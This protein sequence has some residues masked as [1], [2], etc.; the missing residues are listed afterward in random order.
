MSGKQNVLVLG[1]TGSIGENTLDVVARNPERFNVWGLTANTNQAGLF[2]QICKFNP[3]YV[4]LVDRSAAAVLRTRVSELGLSTEVLDGPEALSELAAH[5][6]VDSLMAAIVGAAGLP[7]AMAAAA[8]GKKILLANKESLVCAGR[9]FMDEVDRGGATLLPVD[10]EHNAIFQCM[11]A[12]AGCNAGISK[13]LLTGSGGPFRGRDPD[14]FG[15]VTVE[16]ACTHPNWS[17][18]RKIS[19]DSATMM[20]K[21]LELIEACWLFDIGESEIE[22]LLH[23]ESIVHSMVEYQ[24]GS[25]LAQLGHPDMR[26]PI[27]H[28]L[29]WPERCESGVPAFNWVGQKLNFEAPNVRRYPSLQLAR[30]VASKMGSLPI[31]MN[32]A[33][34]VAVEAFL[35]RR[36]AFTDIVNT[37]EGT[38]DRADFREP[39][40]LD[41]VLDIDSMARVR[42]DVVVDRRACQ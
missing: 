29:S 26:T 23:P 8:A 39:G 11:A 14:T 13:I 1:S 32:A 31:W 33:N 34:E 38:L 16:E 22:I 21:G 6:Q 3:E 17:M 24:D 30:Q 37:I 7:S 20:N 5:D 27:A 28:A 42:A 41:E 36:I 12:S 40:S 25:T 35:Q 15:E 4:A 10:S 19:V 18:G 2:E 9:L